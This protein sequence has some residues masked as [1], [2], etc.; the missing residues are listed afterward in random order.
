VIPGAFYLA[1]I[2]IAV[3]PGPAVIYIVTRSATQGRAAGLASVAGVS[4]GSLGNA[5]IASLG[6]ATLL[7]LSAL[8]FSAVK[9][10]GALY[11]IYLGL[12]AIFGPAAPAP[13]NAPQVNAAGAPDRGVVR[14]IFIDGFLVALFNPKTTIFFAAFVPQFLD[15]STASAWSALQLSLVFVAIASVTDAL[16]A[17]TASRARRWFS[18]RPGTA[19][20][21]RY[22]SGVAF[23]ALGLFTALTGR[24]A[25]D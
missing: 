21:G 6:L 5:I 14:R 2:A 17:I 23:I 4:V 3:T 11:L 7:A 16:Y 13:A 15:T 9:F 18:A 12:R 22:F 25:H 10:A 24:R 1:S 19:R 8:A 20:V